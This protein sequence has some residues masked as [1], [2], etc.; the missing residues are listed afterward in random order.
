[1]ARINGWR[2]KFADH[3]AFVEREKLLAGARVIKPDCDLIAE[4]VAAGRVQHI[5]P[6]RSARSANTGC[7]Y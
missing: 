4:A 5:A 6:S 1:M 7:A 2:Q 3:R